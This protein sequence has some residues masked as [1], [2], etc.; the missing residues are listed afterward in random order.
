MGIQI[1]V[2]LLNSLNKVVVISRIH[3][4]SEINVV[5]GNVWCDLI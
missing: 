3:R 2:S 5:L 1:D 4:A